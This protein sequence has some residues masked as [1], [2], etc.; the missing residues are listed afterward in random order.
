M[1]TARKVEKPVDRFVSVRA[2]GRMIGKNKGTVIA[3]AL[4]GEL[5]HELVAGRTVITR[6]SIETYLAARDAAHQ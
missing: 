2:A 5:E 6:K 3:M 1:S 4:R